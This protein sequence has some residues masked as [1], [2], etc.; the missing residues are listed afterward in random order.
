MFKDKDEVLLPVLRS[1][2]L[3]VSPKEIGLD[4]RLRLRI[5]MGP[6]TKKVRGVFR[7]DQLENSEEVLVENL[8]VVNEVVIDRGPSPYTI[9]LNI[10]IDNNFI[11]CST[12]DGLII[13]TPT[14]STAYNLSAGG[15]ICATSSEVILITPLAP[16]SLSFRPLILP[17]SSEI[18]VEKVND[19]RNAAWVSLDGANRLK[20]SDGESIVIRG[21]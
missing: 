6:N 7:G 3:G 16:H 4:N 11:T 12:G 17:S 14:G 2:A 5:D 15:S 1:S 19:N 20:L 13:S 9:Q 8:H 10:Y 21:A 18:R